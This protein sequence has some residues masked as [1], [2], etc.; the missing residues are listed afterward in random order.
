MQK[1]AHAGANGT[2]Y[3]RDF[4]NVM[5]AGP[6]ADALCLAAASILGEMSQA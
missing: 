5:F 2:R 1:S 3:V 6:P 4:L